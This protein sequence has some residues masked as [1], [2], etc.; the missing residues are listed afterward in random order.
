MRLEE[1]I[2]LEYGYEGEM[3]TPAMHMHIIEGVYARNIEVGTE[4]MVS[5]GME[6][7]KARKIATEKAKINRRG[8]ISYHKELGDI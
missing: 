7:E 3:G 5:E 6:P 4:V 1:E 8:A 2:A